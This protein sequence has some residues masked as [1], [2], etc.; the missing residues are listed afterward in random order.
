[1]ATYNEIYFSKLIASERKYPEI[2]GRTEVP[3]EYHGRKYKIDIKTE[4]HVYEVKF[5]H[6]CWK[7]AVGQVMAYSC[8]TKLDAGLIILI[9]TNPQWHDK[10]LAGYDMLM[11][12]MREYEMDI[13]VYRFYVNRETGAISKRNELTWDTDSD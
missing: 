3:V 12:M 10:D 11:N 6:D 7:S 13:K 4:E 8:L 9:R 1:M 2:F 5:G